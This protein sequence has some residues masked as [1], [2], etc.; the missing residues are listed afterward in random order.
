MSTYEKD[1]IANDARRAKRKQ[2]L[3]ESPICVLCG[4]HDFD[5]LIPVERCIIE[6]HHVIGRVNDDATL[7]QLAAELEQAQPWFGRRPQL[8]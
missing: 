4:F 3:G 1:P 6:M 5:A 8:R 2:Q 7:L